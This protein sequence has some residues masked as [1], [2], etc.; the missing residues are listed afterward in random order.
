MTGGGRE[1]ADTQIAKIVVVRFPR[2]WE[3]VVDRLVSE[4]IKV[5]VVSHGVAEHLQFPPVLCRPFPEVVV[6]K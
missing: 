3:P 5:E 4:R 2:H 1:I 6:I